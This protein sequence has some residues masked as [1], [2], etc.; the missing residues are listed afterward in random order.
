M[1]RASR[2]SDVIRYGVFGGP[3]PGNRAYPLAAVGAEPSSAMSKREVM[4]AAA[5]L[6][7]KGTHSLTLSHGRYVPAI[8]AARPRATRRCW[9]V[10][11]LLADSRMARRVTTSSASC[12]AR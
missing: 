9:E 11:Q 6:R 3:A 5:S 8:V 10:T 1:I 2:P 12:F 4:S 7:S